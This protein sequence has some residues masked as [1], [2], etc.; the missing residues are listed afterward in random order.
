MCLIQISCGAVLNISK[1]ISYQ[2]KINQLQQTLDIAKQRNTQLK[3]DIAGF[4]ATSS[5][6][7]IARNNLKMAGDDEVLVIINSHPKEE[8]NTT[9]NTKFKWDWFKNNG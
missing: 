1:L 8:I 9:T 7:S 3:D 6:E 5:L 4:S 2:A